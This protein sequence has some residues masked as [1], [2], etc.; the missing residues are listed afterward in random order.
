MQGGMVPA[1]PEWEERRYPA[2]ASWLLLLIPLMQ[3]QEMWRAL[4]PGNP[5]VLL[6]CSHPGEIP[7]LGVV[8]PDSKR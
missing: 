3:R 7:E 5:G 8:S 4:F 2:P 6:L 1:D